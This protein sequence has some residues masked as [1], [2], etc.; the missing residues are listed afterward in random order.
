MIIAAI[1]A[2]LE[3]LGAEKSTPGLASLAERLAEA[4]DAI[5]VGDAPTSQA[6]V[7]RELTAVMTKIR[8][9]APVESKGDAVDDIAEQRKKRRA[10]AREQ[11]AG[12]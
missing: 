12:E 9:L 10:A 3:R 6:V 5:P 11:A 7:A 4:L 2:E 8:A 1:R